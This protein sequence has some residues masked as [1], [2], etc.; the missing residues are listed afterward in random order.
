M[1]QQMFYKI[2]PTSTQT[3]EAE[4]HA[5]LRNGK[6]PR[7][8]G[9]EAIEDDADRFEELEVLSETNDLATTIS[10]IAA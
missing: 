7:V 1:T 2:D 10:R 4:M 3:I 8:D 5:L 6:S 9:W